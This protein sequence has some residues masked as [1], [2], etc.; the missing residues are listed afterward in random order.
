MMTDNERQKLKEVFEEQENSLL[1]M[2]DEEAEREAV[3]SQRFERKMD[4]L[5]RRSGGANVVTRTHVR[6]LVVLAAALALMAALAIAGS[7]VLKTIDLDEFSHYGNYQ[8]EKAAEYLSTTDLFQN[9]VDL[10]YVD[11]DINSANND[12]LDYYVDDARNE[13]I[14]NSNGTLRAYKPFEKT[15]TLIREK[16]CAP[17]FGKDVVLNERQAKEYGTEILR[18]M[19]GDDFDKFEF[20]FCEYV[21][22]KY[23]HVVYNQMYADDYIGESMLVRFDQKGNLRLITFKGNGELTNFDPEILKE[24]STAQLNKFIANKAKETEYEGKTYVR[25]DIQ[26][27]MIRMDD[28]KLGIEIKVIV[29]FSTKHGLDDD[30]MS[31]FYPFPDQAAASK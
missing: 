16:V 30:A 7:A 10:Y 11:S 18:K 23:Y 29:T 31:V 6:R 28:G 26:E 14:Y 5:L 13:Y 1:K 24:I 25:H 22:N 3:F 2:I 20:A 8:N 4:R 15:A 27:K 19:R 12:V 9:K 21:N 17:T